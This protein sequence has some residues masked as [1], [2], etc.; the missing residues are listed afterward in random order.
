MPLLCL[1]SRSCK[2]VPGI[3]VEPPGTRASVV[4]IFVLYIITFFV[5]FFRSCLQAGR[6]ALLLP[7]RAALNSALGIRSLRLR[8]HFEVQGSGLVCVLGWDAR[9]RS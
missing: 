4:R 8:M 1:L 9:A 3:P 2:V 6:D 5:F 7:E